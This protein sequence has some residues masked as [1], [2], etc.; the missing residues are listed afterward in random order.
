MMPRLPVAAATEMASLDD[1][2]NRIGIRGDRSCPQLERHVHCHHCDVHAE[3]AKRILDLYPLYGL[4]EAEA[5]AESARVA[6]DAAVAKVLIFRLGEEWLALPLA[7]LS[8]VIPA[9]AIH[10]LPHRRSSTLLGVTNVHGVLAACLSLADILGIDRPATPV[11]G[12][13]GIARL[14]VLAQNG[15]G[16]VV[17]PVDEVDSIQGMPVT[18]LEAS[19]DGK[20]TRALFRWKEHG[21][22]LLD[23]SLLWQ[24]MR[25]S[26]T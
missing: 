12:R 13:R 26:L 21:V 9:Q 1:C 14:L 8:E 3:A 18:G 25:R 15:E 17:C 24:A 11:P 7:L 23:E 22:R 5:G 10:A 19:G 4:S 16:G 6:P 2:W 20:C